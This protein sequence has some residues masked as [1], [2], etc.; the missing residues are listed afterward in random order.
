MSKHNERGAK[1]EEIA[2]NFLVTNRYS[3]LERNWRSGKKEI[4]IIAQKEDLV[5][6]IEVKTRKDFSFGYP[7]EAVTPQKERF[8]KAAADAYIEANP[9]FQ[10]FRFDIISILLNQGKVKEIKHFEDVFF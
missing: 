4:D 5:I 6:F 9:Q 3:I 1:G 10:K 2:V 7:E 8:L